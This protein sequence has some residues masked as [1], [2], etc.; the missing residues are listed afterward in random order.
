MA[1]T[2]CGSH[3]YWRFS[4]TTASRKFLLAVVIVNRQ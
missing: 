3:F 4:M 1:S 2:V